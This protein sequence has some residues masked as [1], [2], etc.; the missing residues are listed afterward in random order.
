MGL[1]F[2]DARP[3]NQSHPMDKPR[4]FSMSTTTRFLRR[5]PADV[6][7]WAETC[8]QIRCL[9]EHKDQA[10]GEVHHVHIHDAKLHYHERT[11]EF[12]YVIAGHGTMILDDEVIELHEGVVVYVPRGIKHKAMG[13]LTVLTVCVPAGVLGDIHEV[14]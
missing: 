14:E 6:R 12:Y 1:S 13:E 9:I 5:D 2:S 8:G 7:P 3:T 11:D 4:S 10:A